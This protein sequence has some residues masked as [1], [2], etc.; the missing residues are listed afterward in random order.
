[1]SLELRTV[2]L[3]RGAQHISRNGPPRSRGLSRSVRSG[4]DKAHLCRWTY[5]AVSETLVRILIP[6]NCART[7]GNISG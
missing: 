1:M 6:R 5:V 4:K 2:L 3:V 7:A